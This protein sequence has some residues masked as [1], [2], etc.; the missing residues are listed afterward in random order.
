[1]K[2]LLFIAAFLSVAVMF[3]S[4]F[5]PTLAHSENTPESSEKIVENASIAPKYGAIPLHFEQNVGQTNEQVKFLTRGTGYSLFLTSDEAVLAMRSAKCGV[6][7]EKQNCPS[8]VLKMKIAGANPLA[9]IIGENLLEGKT[10]YITGDDPNEWKTGITNY[11]R[12]RYQNVYDGIDIVYYG[13][14]KQLEYDF[15]VSPNA[16]LRSIALVFN[17]AR[18]F[19]IDAGGDLVFKFGASQLRQHRPVAYQEIDGMRQEI[20]AN[21][22][23][24]NDKGQR[25]KNEIK[26]EVAEYD[27][28]KPLVI[29]PVLSY[30]TYLGGGA[31]TFGT[32]IAVDSS[33]SAYI[34]GSTNALDFPNVNPFQ[35][36]NAGGTA[37]FVTKLNPSGTAFVY[38]TYLGG[39]SRTFPS[40]IKV[41]AAGSAYV[42]GVTLSSNFPTTSGAYRTTPGVNSFITKLSPSGASLS[43]STFLA[44]VDQLTGIALDASNNA[45]VTGFTRD[46]AFPTTPGAFKPTLAGGLQ[47][48]FVTKLNTAGSA[49]IYSTFVGA[50][51]SVAGAG[52][53]DQAN[54]IAIDSTGSAYITGVTSS[55]NFPVTPGAFQIFPG[56]R[57][58]AFVAKLNAAGSA[59]VYA[60]YLGGTSQDKGTGIAVDAA[61]NAYVTGSSE[62][63]TTDFPFTA[64]SFLPMAARAGSFGNSFLAKVNA[65][66]TALVYSTSLIFRNDSDGNGVAV[67]S[68]GS[69]YVV[70][71]EGFNGAYSVNAIQPVSRNN[72]SFIVKMNPTG[73]ALT[74]STPFGGGNGGATGTAIAIDASGNAYVTGYTT[75][76]DFSVTPGAPQS[77]KPGGQSYSAFVAKIGIQI[78]ECAAIEVGPQALP[79]V[80]FGQ[81]YSQKL[82]AAGGVGPYTFSLAPNFP[83]NVLP[84]TMTLAP[85]GTI[86]GNSPFRD[87]GTYYITVQAMSSTGCTGVRTL[88]LD[89]VERQP[90][91]QVSVIGRTGILRARENRY[92]FI[93]TNNGD[94]DVIM[95]PL[96]VNIPKYFT[97][98]PDF[99]LLDTIQPLAGPAIDYRQVPLDY[100]KGDQT[101]IPLLL[102]RIRARSTGSVSIIISVPNLPE[103]LNTNFQIDA[104]LGSPLL[105]FAP[106]SSAEGQS[107]TFE[108]YSNQFNLRSHKLCTDS[109]PTLPGSATSAT[110]VPLT[111]CGQ[112]IQQIGFDLLGLIPGVNCEV[113][114]TFFLANLYASYVDSGGDVAGTLTGG[115]A[116]AYSTAVGCVLGASPIGQVVAAAQTGIDI[117]LALPLC[118]PP[119]GG[120]SFI[121]RVVGSNDPNDKSGSSGSGMSHYFSGDAPY[122]YIIQFENKSS[123]T[124]PAQEVVVT[125]QL[126]V[127]K[128]D[129]NTLSLNDINIGTKRL[130]P[131]PN[132]SAFFKDFDLRPTNNIITRITAALDRSTGIITWRFQ[133]IDPATGLPTDDPLAGFLPPNH[134]GTEGQGSVMFTIKLKPGLAT[135][136]EVRNK[137]TIVFDTNAAIDT[138]E[139]LNT[140]DTAKPVSHVLPL[141]ASVANGFTLNLTG[142]DVGSGVGSYTIYISTD[143]GPFAPYISNTPLT[144]VVAPPLAVNHTYRFYS[145]ARDATGNEETSKTSAEAV[146][147]VNLVPVSGRALTSDGRGLRNATVSI[148]DSNGVRRTTTTS[149]F[150]FYQFDNV[151]IGGAYTVSVSSRLFRF[152]P[153]V[154]QVTDTLTN[155]DFTGLE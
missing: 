12:V 25:T 60:S 21:Y 40:S 96:I 69:A 36:T 134:D 5:S 147:T 117:A 13:N 35:S 57:R 44:V 115:L 99:K 104:H 121:G 47:N 97:W 93:Y 38:S 17:G 146:T 31:D 20:A 153:L 100:Q 52:V 59:L 124:A 66:G 27:H 26:F 139:W 33:G 137:A 98:R 152:A 61:G 145:I 58:D 74:Y 2:I 7:S 144:S 119:G 111:P 89:F 8:H 94:T 32:S 14:Q 73:T 51:A 150:G 83:N 86:S 18:K 107:S 46:T 118:F 76:S 41:D 114:V 92:T 138:P 101:V 10:N 133:S 22:V 30:S 11:E 128:F 50:A 151:L 29:D 78:N 108:S 75:A 28:T 3:S 42:A 88:K 110:A 16:D 154:L 4:D 148:T 1:M 123:A 72:D 136:T 126:D 113:Q 102:P 80:I 48:S 19:K 65:A 140:I 130:A 132:T 34:T 63:F 135:G 39:N 122:P 127:S 9:E 82:T 70:G 67:D 116:G 103:Y 125:D 106:A 53:N 141:P 23:I 129:L 45:Y 77:T 120:G 131:L 91:L 62:V 37:A 87:F 54:A 155:V 90:V 71:G 142:T 79:A 68:T 15:V 55:Q 81:S 105:N 24:A 95:V 84:R 143:G 43:Y 85:D 56:Q 149:S 109:L 64:T 49:L 6:R 112:A